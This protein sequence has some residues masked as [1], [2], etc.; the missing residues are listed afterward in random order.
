MASIKISGLTEQTTANDTDLLPVASSAGMAKQMTLANFVTW[1]A[2][3]LNSKFAP[4]G[5]GLG[6]FA[7]DVT[8]KNLND[9]AHNGFYQ[10]STA[11]NSPFDW[12]Y[13]LHIES[14]ESATQIAYA[15]A[16]TDG[17]LNATK[18]RKKVGWG[19]WGEWEWVNPPMGLG[20]EYRTTERWQGKS[21]YAMAVDFGTMPN[22][23]HKILVHGI[24]NI[25]R[26]IFC[27]GSSSDG[28]ILP[29]HTNAHDVELSANTTDIVIKNTTNWSNCTAVVV[30]KYTKK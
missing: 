20:V 11:I 14:G 23:T 17:Y 27:T 5:Y 28:C 19:T 4:A 6:G 21:V 15:I 26:V 1:L 30:L 24:S 22:S 10:W 12:G 9:I 18:T 13:M 3:K 7:Q 29:Y 8:G 16:Y 2:S 25:E